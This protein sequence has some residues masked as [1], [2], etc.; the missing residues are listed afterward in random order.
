M[1]FSSAS[2]PRWQCDGTPRSRG[3]AGEPDAS[4]HGVGTE[5][6]WLPGA[7]APPTQQGQRHLHMA[8]LAAPQA[9]GAL[10]GFPVFLVMGG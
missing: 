9:G 6:R 8:V 2:G 7:A 10:G 5:E 3:A 1:L 4:G